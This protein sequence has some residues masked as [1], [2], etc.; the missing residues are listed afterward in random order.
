MQ[1]HEHFSAMEAIKVALY[2]IVIFG[3]LHLIAMKFKD[4]SKFWQAWANLWGVS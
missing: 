1:I 2:V 3:T 4:R